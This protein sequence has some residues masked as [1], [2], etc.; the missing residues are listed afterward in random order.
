[1]NHFPLKTSLI[2]IVRIIDTCLKNKKKNEMMV[3]NEMLKKLDEIVGL[4]INN[5]QND[6]IGTDSPDCKI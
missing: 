5:H 1:M 6:S 4:N 2:T 3:A